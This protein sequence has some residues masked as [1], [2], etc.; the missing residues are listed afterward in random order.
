[1]AQWVRIRSWHVAVI[2]TPAYDPFAEDP[3]RGIRVLTRCGRPTEASDVADSFPF[4]ERTCE[5][6]LRLEAKG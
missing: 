1:M 6:C 3:R 2:V 4:G 5:S